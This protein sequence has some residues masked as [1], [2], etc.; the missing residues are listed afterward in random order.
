MEAESLH[1]QSQ[2]DWIKAGVV[3]NEHNEP[4]LAEKVL[5]KALQKDPY[6]AVA[7]DQLIVSLQ[8]QGQYSQALR[9]AK[10]LIRIADSSY[11]QYR[12]AEIYYLLNL[13]EHAL[14]HY[15][16]ALTQLE[17]DGPLL[18]EIYKNM[19]N[20]LVR[21]GDFDS[22]QEYY[23]KSY[24]L[25]PHSAVLLVNYGTLE[26][27]RENYDD[28]KERFRAAVAIDHRLDRGWVGIA[29]VHRH[30]GDFEISRA[31]LER[32]LDISPGNKVALKL[33][34]E[35]SVADGHLDRA[36]ERVQAYLDTTDMDDEIILMHSQ[37]LWCKGRVDDAEL[38]LHR[39][40]LVNPESN[41]ALAYSRFLREQ[42][43]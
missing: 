13:D 42:H 18:F 12:I 33:L 22:A 3:L 28:A 25:N 29:L 17:F 32:A 39:A 7:I 36:L 14:T 2:D 8:K 30:C 35:W 27:Q 19:G 41:G 16:N 38:E 34:V 31:N 5:Y 43:A 4:R 1:H 6:D 37:L 11:S 15:Q 24:T 26:L 20:I 9:C 40:L 23:D 21:Q 10:A